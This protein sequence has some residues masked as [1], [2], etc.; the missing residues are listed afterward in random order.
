MVP[1]AAI[2]QAFRVEATNVST[3]S[4]QPLPGTNFKQAFGLAFFPLKSC[5]NMP[6]PT[7]T[8]KSSVVLPKGV[9]TLV[10]WISGPSNNAEFPPLFTNSATFWD[11]EKSKH[12]ANTTMSP[13]L[14]ALVVMS[15]LPPL[16]SSTTTRESASTS[17]AMSLVTASS[18]SVGVGA[19]SKFARHKGVEP[20]C[21]TS[22]NKTVCK[23]SACTV[24]KGSSLESQRLVEV[25]EDSRAF[26]SA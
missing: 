3:P 12:R 17:W 25:P 4:L 21:A 2:P 1:P 5:T 24:T 22:A 26:S 7:K 18:K 23:L 8:A 14:I 10:M 11:L 15:D 9:S 13:S 6:M 19:W 20:S 16:A